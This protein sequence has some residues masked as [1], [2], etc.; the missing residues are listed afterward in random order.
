MVL[1]E[2]GDCFGLA[3]EKKGRGKD[4]HVLASLINCVDCGAIS[5]R[6]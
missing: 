3:G 2:L 1:A 4:D 5:D 6:K